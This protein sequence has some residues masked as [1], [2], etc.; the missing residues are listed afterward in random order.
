MLESKRLKEVILRLKGK[1]LCMTLPL[2][3]TQLDT[4]KGN[5]IP[6]PVKDTHLLHEHTF[7]CIKMLVCPPLVHCM[8]VGSVIACVM[9]SLVPR[10]SLLTPSLVGRAWERGYVM[11]L[12]CLGSRIATRGTN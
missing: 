1:M 5:N 10:L 6:N 12:S 2:C 3:S 7:H 8:C 11:T 9:T 4:V